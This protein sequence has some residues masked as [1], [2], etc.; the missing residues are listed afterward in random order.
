MS[1]NVP[2]TVSYTVAKSVSSSVKANLTAAKGRPDL[3]KDTRSFFEKLG[4]KVIGNM[5][6]TEG[7]IMAPTKKHKYM[8]D[9]GLSL[10]TALEKSTKDFFSVEKNKKSN[11]IEALRGVYVDSEE[12]DVVVTIRPTLYGITIEKG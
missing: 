11:F 7:V 1:K 10:K 2:V 5:P 3:Y 9:S 6:N 4:Y 8:G 12:D